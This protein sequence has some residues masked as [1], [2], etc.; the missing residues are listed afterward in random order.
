MSKDRRKIPFPFKAEVNAFEAVLKEE[1]GSMLNARRAPYVSPENTLAYHHGRTWQAHHSSA[2]DETGT[3][4]AHEHFMTIPFKDV[5]ANDLGLLD[6]KIQELVSGMHS[7][8]VEGIF[9]T[10]SKACEKSG[11]VVSDKSLSP[12]DQ[13]LEALRTVE[14]GVDRNGE[15]SIPAFHGGNLA[16][17]ALLKDLRSKGAEFEEEVERIK[18][19]KIAA[20]RD[21][22]AERKA[23]FVKHD[24]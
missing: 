2:P 18:A 3:M 13:F 12:A 22:E 21:R 19:E 1:I 20:A 8:I 16:V 11:N 15:P 7:T 14:F 24:E 9:E 23:R 4:V 10:V 6:R 5:V 17:D